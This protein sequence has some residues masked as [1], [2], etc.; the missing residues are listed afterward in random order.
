[1]AFN[2]QSH[3][4]TYHDGHWYH[5]QS[6]CTQCHKV[7]QVSVKGEDLF[8]YHNNMGLLQDLFP[9]LTAGE[10]E[11]LFQSNIC[12]SCFDKLFEEKP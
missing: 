4:E 8:K 5:F 12:S 9:Y 7:F 3:T 1:M 6:E 10:R 11:L 2:Y